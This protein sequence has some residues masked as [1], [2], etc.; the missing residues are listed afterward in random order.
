MALYYS[1]LALA[2]AVGT[3]GYSI[4]DDEALGILRNSSGV[5]IG[6]IQLTLLYACLEAVTT[7]LWLAIF[8]FSSGQRRKQLRETFR[9]SRWQ[10]LVTGLKSLEWPLYLRALY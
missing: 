7:V 5:S 2:A 9:D 10:A 3:A 1:A 8:A 4:I 6:N